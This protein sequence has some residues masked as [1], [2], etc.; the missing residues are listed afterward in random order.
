[1]RLTL[2]AIALISFSFG[3]VNAQSAD[4]TPFQAA[5]A[6]QEPPLALATGG[7][8]PVAYPSLKS[9]YDAI[10]PS[11]GPKTLYLNFL[12][13]YQVGFA[14]A[15]EKFNTI[16]A[17]GKGFDFH[18][19]IGPS[20]QYGIMG[21]AHITAFSVVLAYSYFDVSESYNDIDGQGHSN[22]LKF[23]YAALPIA[24]TGIYGADRKVGFFYQLGVTP[25][26]AVTAQDDNKEIK[27]LKRFAVVP[28]G[29]IGM[30]FP[31]TM[32]KSNANVMRLLGVYYSY[33]PG[34]MSNTAGVTVNAYSFGLRYTFMVVR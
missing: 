10:A 16:S 15:N 26:F 5:R 14:N 18:F 13:G 32:R 30:A 6:G 19:E 2:L 33:T 20:I 21:D 9:G 17:K 28:Y 34:N 25:K 27:D 3:K 1:M 22:D 7:L 8:K 12:T 24:Y 4:A 11:Q 31:G 29:C 23:N